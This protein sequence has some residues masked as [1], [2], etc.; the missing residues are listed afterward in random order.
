[1]WTFSFLDL[2]VLNTYNLFLSSFTSASR[3]QSSGSEWGV[4]VFPGY[5]KKNQVW[6]LEPM[7]TQL[8][9]NK[10]NLS[11]TWIFHVRIRP[12]VDESVGNKSIFPPFSTNSW[13]VFQVDD[14]LHWSTYFGCACVWC[15]GILKELLLTPRI[16]SACLVLQKQ[17]RN[18]IFSGLTKA[19]RSINHTL[20]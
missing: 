17:Q 15:A 18:I 12:R 1:M 14:S 10:D 19:S 16:Q 9:G 20:L 11:V 2:P 13:D 3:M 5:K 6:E 7:V 8:T 4:E